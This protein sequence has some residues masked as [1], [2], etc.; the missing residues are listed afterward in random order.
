MYLGISIPNEKYGKLCKCIAY[1]R[2]HVRVKVVMMGWSEEEKG[3]RL[4]FNSWPEQEKGKN[5][6]K[7][8]FNLK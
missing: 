6:F 2:K 4:E 8:C 5:I 7:L 3:Y 1:M